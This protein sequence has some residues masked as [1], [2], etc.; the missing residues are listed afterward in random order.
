MPTHDIM[1][2]RNERRVLAARRRSKLHVYPDDWKGLPI[3]PLR[4][5]GQMEIVKL[6]DAILGEFKRHGY[7]LPEAAAGRVAALEREIDERVAALYGVGRS[8]P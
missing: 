2:N 7:P 5:E 8:T 3:V 4:M 6:V 1:D